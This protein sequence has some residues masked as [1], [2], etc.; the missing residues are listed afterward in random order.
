MSSLKL[1]DDE[2][3]VLSDL[4][5]RTQEIFVQVGQL[6]LRKDSLLDQ[7]RQANHQAQLKMNEAATRLGIPAGTPWQM[8]PD[9]TV[10]VLDPTTGQPVPSSI[11]TP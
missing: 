4:H 2:L 10:L 8:M 3:K 5:R 6:A 7:A 1:N 9:G 11:V